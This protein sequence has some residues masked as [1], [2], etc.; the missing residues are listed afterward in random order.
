MGRGHV[1]GGVKAKQRGDFKG[2]L[3]NFDERNDKNL[4]TKS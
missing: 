1:S 2:K 4:A 3:T